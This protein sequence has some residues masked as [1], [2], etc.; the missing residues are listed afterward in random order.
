MAAFNAGLTLYVMPEHT[1]G[2]KRKYL[3]VILSP[4]L[5]PPHSQCSIQRCSASGKS[6]ATLD[7]SSLAQFPIPAQFHFIHKNPGTCN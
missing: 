5:L 3:T 2:R 1:V 4:S 6:G 7:H